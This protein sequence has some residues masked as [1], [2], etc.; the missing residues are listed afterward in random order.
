VRVARYRCPGG[1]DVDQRVDRF[2]VLAER[3]A[4]QIDPVRP[5][6]DGERWTVRG[7]RERE[8]RTG[9]PQAVALE[10]VHAPAVSA[11][12]HDLHGT[13]LA[14][15]RHE[16]IDRCRG[17][18]R[19]GDQDAASVPPG[20]CEAAH[21]PGL[22]VDDAGGDTTLLIDPLADLLSAALGLAEPIFLLGDTEGENR[23]AIDFGRQTQ[24]TSEHATPFASLKCQ[25]PL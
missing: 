20:S 25:D 10:R 19:I 14:Q 18:H 9:V 12:R 21:T 5:V 15:P 8:R 16:N 3:V 24:H 7:P 1:V 4:R 11:E 2:V 6:R 17:A 22:D 13:V 23:V